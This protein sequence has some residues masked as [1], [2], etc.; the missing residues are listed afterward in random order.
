MYDSSIAPLRYEGEGVE[1]IAPHVLPKLL[2][3][4]VVIVAALRFASPLAQVICACL[5]LYAL[6]GARQSLEAL[7]LLAFMLIVGGG[8]LSLLRWI[9]LFAAFG[10]A[11]WDGILLDAPWPRFFAPLLAFF[12]V[13]LVFSLLTSQMPIVSAFKLISFTVGVG[14]VFTAFHRTLHLRDYWLAWFFTLS[15]FIVLTSAPLAGTSLGYERGA[16]FQGILSHPQT[17][18]PISAT[19]ASF[20]TG[21][22]LFH[23]N[24]SKLVMISAVLAWTGLYGSQSRTALL[25]AILGL[26]IVVGVGL[27]KTQSWQLQIKRVATSLGTMVAAVVGLAFIAIFWSNVQSA[28]VGFLLKDEGQASVVASLEDSRG[29][30]IERSMSNFYSAP[31]TGIGL[32]VPSDASRARVETGAFGLPVGASVEKGFMPSAVLEETGIVGAILV[33]LMIGYLIW[34]VI[35]GAPLALFWM[36]LTSLLVNFGE[37]VFFSV[38][39]MGFYFWIIMAFCYTYAVASLIDRNAHSPIVR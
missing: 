4:L 27:F 3:V 35:H 17:F 19:I 16:G 6:R 22:C 2:G 25:A 34:P 31:I 7:S 5:A 12:A 1:R 29:G 13:I 33:V 8:N 30:L 11:L 10:R 37:M 18:G 15:I 20:L 28:I 24:R 23:Q 38:G 21:L 14:T 36:L 32:G 39:G 26:A 9:V